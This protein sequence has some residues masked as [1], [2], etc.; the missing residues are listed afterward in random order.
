[1]TWDRTSEYELDAWEKTLGNEGWNWKNLYAAMLKVESFLPS[2]AYGTEGVGKTGPIQTLVNRIFPRHQDTWYPTMNGLGLATNRESLNGNPIGVSTQP[3]NVSPN[4]TRSYAPEYLKLAQQNVVVKLETR[5]AKIN[6]RGKTATGVILEDGTAITA[7]REVILSAGTFQTPGLLEISGIGNATLLE[8]LD[9]PVIKHLPSVGENLQDHIRIQTSYQLKS[10]Y[11]SF[12]VLKNATRAAAELALYNAD[13]VS[14]YDYT[15][16][17]YAYFPWN[18]VSNDTTSKLR[19]LVETDKGLT[20]VTEK[21]KR[22]YFSP[23]LSTKVPQLEV[24]FSDGY[25]GL[26]GYPAANS[27]QFGIGT[28]A[29]IGVVQHPFSKGYVHIISSNISDKPTINPNYLSH[30]Y[31]LQAATNLAKFLRKIASSKPMSDVW[32][33]EY[34][35]GSSV[36]SDDEWTKYALANTLSIYHPIGTAALLPEK[37]G[38]VVDTK[39]KVYGTKGLRVVDASVIPLLPSAHLQTLV[40]GIAEKAAEMIIAEHEE[41]V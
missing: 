29:L 7:R 5:V 10:E 20:S 30:P 19:T 36:Q 2:P 17:G 25:T 38:G 21:L 39:L 18:V 37:D 12:D 27:S 33:E 14:L 31:D 22:S 41:V 26:R 4:Y 23:A 35:P 40:Y 28:F 32:T 15:A 1:M 16:S 13:R 9:I 8:R 6:F 11:P 24:I 34:E 3:S